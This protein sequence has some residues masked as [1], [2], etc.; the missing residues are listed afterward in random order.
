MSFNLSMPD[1]YHVLTTREKWLAFE[2]LEQGKEITINV[3]LDG[4]GNVIAAKL[5]A[6]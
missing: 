6:V 5:I 2:A 4:E 3:T 1:W